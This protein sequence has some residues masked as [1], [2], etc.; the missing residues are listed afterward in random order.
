MT[1]APQPVCDA[2]RNSSTAAD[3]MPGCCICT[4][5]LA[6][7]RARYCSAACRQRSFRLR[8]VHPAAVD[9]QDL[10]A[11]LRRRGALVTHTLYECS[12]CGERSVGERRCAECNVFMRAA[13]LG[14]RCTACDQP[15]LLAELLELEVLS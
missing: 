13:G 15:I 8:H 9:D 14:G 4:R 10:R 6:S 1:I 5:P 3:G 11:E 7:R 2:S 12:Q